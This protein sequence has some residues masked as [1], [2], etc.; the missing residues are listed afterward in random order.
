MESFL[1]ELCDSSIDVNKLDSK[2]RSPA[3]LA[4]IKGEIQMMNLLLRCG[5]E[6]Y[7]RS[8]PAM[9][10]YAEWI[11]ESRKAEESQS[12]IEH[13]HADGPANRSTRVKNWQLPINSD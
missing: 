9:R 5:G 3:D 11:A 1:E 7:I 10:K 4:A 2:G 12:G 13:V 8:K 6:F